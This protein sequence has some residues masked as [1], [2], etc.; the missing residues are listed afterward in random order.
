[1]FCKKSWNS[2]NGGFLRLTL[3]QNKQESDFKTNVQ[4]SHYQK[5]KY[6][7]KNKKIIHCTILKILTKSVYWTSVIR[8][9]TRQHASRE[10]WQIFVAEMISHIFLFHKLWNQF[11]HK[12]CITVIS[13]SESTNI[14]SHIF[15]PYTM[16]LRDIH[17]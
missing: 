16:S 8:P 17:S 11:F 10:Y 3:T 5:K 14:I 4:I 13:E 7:S 6:K 12:W 1:M 2:W 15:A 9:N